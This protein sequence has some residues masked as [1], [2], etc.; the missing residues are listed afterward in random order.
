MKD[1]VSFKNLN[2]TDENKYQTIRGY[3]LLNC[4]KGV[5]V[6]LVLIITKLIIRD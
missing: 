5:I 3:N 4:M 2:S 1:P 6:N